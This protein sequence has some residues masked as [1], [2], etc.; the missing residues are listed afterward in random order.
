MVIG[1]E[2]RDTRPDNVGTPNTRLHIVG[3][4]NNVKMATD[5]VAEND[6]CRGP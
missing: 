6:V 2:V 5:I 3:R 1:T 4:Q